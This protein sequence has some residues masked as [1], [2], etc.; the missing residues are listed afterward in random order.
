MSDPVESTRRR[1]DARGFPVRLADGQPWLL[2]EPAFHPGRAVL[3]TPDVDAAIDRFHEQ[4][5]LGEDLWLADVQAVARTLLLANYEL[6]E[7]ELADLLEVAPGPEA[8][9]LAGAVL[10]SLFGTD[11]RARATATGSAPAS[12]P[13][14]W[15]APR[16]QPRRSATSS[17]S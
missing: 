14:A 8:E 3:T 6:S 17:P 15:I 11:S 9:A 16:S 12:W 4:I 7:G 5:V 10:G 1:P 2:A 13:T